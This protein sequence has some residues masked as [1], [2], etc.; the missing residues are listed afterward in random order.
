MKY[1]VNEILDKNGH[2][3]AFEP[4]GVMRCSLW[5]TVRKITVEFLSVFKE[6][7]S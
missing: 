5:K 1:D 6:W 3:T 7:I 4:P 2:T